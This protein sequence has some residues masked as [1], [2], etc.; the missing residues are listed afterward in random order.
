M[1]RC[2]YM[3]TR[4]QSVS[5]HYD[6]RLT[7]PNEDAIHPFDAGIVEMQCLSKERCEQEISMMKDM[8]YDMTSELRSALAFL[9]E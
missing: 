7:I 4:N 2:Y 5:D 9:L 3:A 8:G 6:L 1:G